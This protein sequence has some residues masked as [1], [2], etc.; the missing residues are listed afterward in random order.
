[1][2]RITSLCVRHPWATL[3]VTLL[4]TAIAGW[5]TLRTH[6]AVGTDANLG[7]NHPAVQAFGEFLSRFGGGYPIVIAFECADAQVCRSALDPA[8]LEMAYAI[9]RQ[10]EQSSFVSSVASPATS[11]LLVP[12]PDLGVDARRLVVD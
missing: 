6:L 8:A 7:A 11:Q 1:M 4:L 3:S 5:S 12:S 9:T 2:P 10:L